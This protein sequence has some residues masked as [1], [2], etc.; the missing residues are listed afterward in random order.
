VSSF[1]FSVLQIS[2]ESSEENV[3]I[4]FQRRCFESSER[5]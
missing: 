4:Y 2:Q 5:R 3:E 1:A